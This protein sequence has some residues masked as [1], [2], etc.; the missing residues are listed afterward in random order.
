MLSLYYSGL[1]LK[2][3]EIAR[4]LSNSYNDL[5]ALDRSEKRN[6]QAHKHQETGGVTYENQFE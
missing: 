4:I 1:D 6:R 5:V 3:I 2:E